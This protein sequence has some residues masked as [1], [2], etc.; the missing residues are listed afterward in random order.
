MVRL[1]R[2]HLELMQR[3]WNTKALPSWNSTSRIAQG[4]WC[5]R[6]FLFDMRAGQW[7][8]VYRHADAQYRDRQRGIWVG[9]SRPILETLQSL[10]EVT[11]AFGTLC[12]PL[13]G[14]DGAGLDRSDRRV[15]G[16]SQRQSRFRASGIKGESRLYRCEIRQA[17]K[18]FWFHSTTKIAVM[19]GLER[20]SLLVLFFRK[21]HSLFPI[22][23]ERN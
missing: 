20:K 12:M 3:M 6:V 14:C 2:L 23:A 19:A 15:V 11:N 13:R 7:T 21:E 8:L 10:H 5:N 22:A 1:C 4:K 16:R 18:T 9:S 17:A